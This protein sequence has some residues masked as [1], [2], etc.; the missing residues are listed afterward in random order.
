MN[1]WAS[2]LNKNHRNR[3]NVQNHI[4][5]L[6]ENYSTE[7]AVKSRASSA[8]PDWNFSRVFHLP[9]AS[10]TSGSCPG[11]GF[12]CERRVEIKPCP[13]CCQNAF[14]GRN[15]KFCPKT[16]I[17]SSTLHQKKI[18]RK[19]GN[20]WKPYHLPTCF[21]WLVPRRTVPPDSDMA[22]VLQKNSQVTPLKTH[23][24]SASESDK[25]NTTEICDKNKNQK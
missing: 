17:Q 6:N 3:G 24:Q 22:S 16:R 13:N 5:I 20:L 19:V 21:H 1:T 23:A 18:A 9:C 15:W 4:L 2:L 11:R 14:G 25:Q 10:F 7:V 8:S 12:T